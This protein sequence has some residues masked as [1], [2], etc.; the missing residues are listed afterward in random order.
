[1]HSSHGEVLGNRGVLTEPAKVQ[2]SGRKEAQEDPLSVTL[3]QRRRRLS[4]TAKEI[5]STRLA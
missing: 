5:T 4:K 3:A 2:P 1:M